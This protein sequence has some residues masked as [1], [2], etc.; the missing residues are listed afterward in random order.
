MKQK[1]SLA[2]VVCGMLLA[3]SLGAQ[4]SPSQVVFGLY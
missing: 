4:D 2:I 3:S 1:Y